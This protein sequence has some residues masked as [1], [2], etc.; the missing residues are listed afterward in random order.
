MTTILAIDPGT[1]R[2]AWLLLAAGGRPTAFGKVDNDEL[3]A[4][5]R[6]D[7]GLR[8]DPDVLVIE[9]ITSYGTRPVG[10]ET[11]HT[12]R[13]AGRFEEALHGTPV[14]YVARG[15]VARQLGARGDAGVRAAC[16]D[17]FGGKDAAI[18]R[19]AAPG[20]LYG[21]ATDVW[22]ALALAIAYEEGAR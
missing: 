19:K 1:H 7:R 13:Q 15:T 6:G 14:V 3:V 21:I 12:M 8:P 17:R 16:I 2:S 18:G 11:F 20:P 4:R 5:L 22:S 9:E 10:R